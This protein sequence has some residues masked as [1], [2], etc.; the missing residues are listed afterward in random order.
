MSRNVKKDTDFEEGE[1]AL[2]NLH[3]SS[4][5][6]TVLALQLPQR[7][8]DCKTQ[9]FFGLFSAFHYT[10]HT[11]FGRIMEEDVMPIQFLGVPKA[12]YEHWKT[13][14]ESAV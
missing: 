13:D 9:T 2:T 4:C 14:C 10:T 8:I 6:L 12:H 5:S 3:S 1:G 7:W 11:I